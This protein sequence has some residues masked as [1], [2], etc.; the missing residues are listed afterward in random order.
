[1][2]FSADTYHARRQ[3]LRSELTTGLILASF[4]ILCG[5][6]AAATPDHPGRML[7]LQTACYQYASLGD[8]IQWVAANG[9]QVMSFYT[10]M[11]CVSVYAL[12]SLVFGRKRFNL[13]RMLHRG[14]YAVRD[15]TVKGDEGVASHWR[16]LG[17][18]KEFTW[19]DKVIYLGSVLWIV[20]WGVFFLAVTGYHYLICNI[21]DE[22]WISFWHVIVWMSL[23]LAVAV[24]SWFL[25]GGM[26]D[27]KDMF[28]LLRTRVRDESD[29]G[30]VRPADKERSSACG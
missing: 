3:R 11:S 27:L 23:G 18:G 8:L 12:V 20:M 24:T 2:M 9:G 17:V 15:D 7:S 21:S 6:I 30:F 26:R 25:I 1:M 22:A 4:S 19:W 14:Q 28:H 16:W 10:A 5:Q 29:D 13:D